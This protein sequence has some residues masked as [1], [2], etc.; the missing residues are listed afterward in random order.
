MTLFP[1]KTN[2]ACWGVAEGFPGC[3]I[4]S[5]QAFNWLGTE[6][7]YIGAPITI[8]SLSRNSETR[9]FDN[10][11][12]ESRRV[13]VAGRPVTGLNSAAISPV[14]WLI[15]SFTRSR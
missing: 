13:V 4:L 6:K 8:T 9:A 11:R 3:A 2:R 15:S 14:R 10:S 7:L 12:S 5:I 1:R